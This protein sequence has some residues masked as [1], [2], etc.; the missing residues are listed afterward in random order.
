MRRE[1]GPLR[2]A[3][4]F[5]LAA[6]V[7]DSP[8]LYV[9]GVALA[10][11][12]LLL[13]AWVWAARRATTIDRGEGPWTV[14]EGE[15][16]PLDVRIALGRLPFP[17]GRIEHPFLR[18]PLP[19]G[20]RWSRRSRTPRLDVDLRFP[21]RG[22]TELEPLTLRIA[23]PLGLHSATVR[24]PPG[25]TVLVLPRV[26]PVL[27][28]GG[29]GGGTEPDLAGSLGRG[30]GGSG[31]ERESID[32]EIDG[33]RPYRR[34]SPASRIHWPSV[35]RSGDLLELRLVA[36]GE[37]PPLVSLDTRAPADLDALDQA[38]RAAASLCLHLAPLGGCALAIPGE[39]S[40]RRIDS[41][42][43]GWGDARAALATVEA[44]G[45]APEIASRAAEAV[46]RVCAGE[47]GARDAMRMQSGYLVSQVVPP[48]SQPA[49]TVCGYVGQ[50]L[51]ARRAAASILE[52]VA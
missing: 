24:S 20:P 14:V 37:A 12:D 21:R 47:P 40:P 49:F 38:V 9:P 13:R 27:V 52:R 36:G 31:L 42:L 45:R 29:R 50:R 3:G 19:I 34:G 51:D 16:Y 6:A 33:L 46:F 39:A 18:R 35:A 11:L 48:G 32:F 30:P 5:V 23:D 10:L 28:G 22:R 41:S 26:E 7:F 17:G 15:P 25:A 4:A 2:L 1:R 44:G 43:R 8:S